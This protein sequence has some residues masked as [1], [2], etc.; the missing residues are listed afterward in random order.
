MRQAINPQQLLRHLGTGIAVSI[1]LIFV[2]L[3][4]VSG[5]T[6]GLRDINSIEYAVIARNLARTGHFATDILKPLSL[7]RFPTV[8]D[9]PDLIY[10]PLH[11]LWESLWMRM[12]GDP[13]K[14]V[15]LASGAWL[16]LGGL[17]MLWLGTVWFDAR[18][19]CAAALLYV[20]NVNMLDLAADGTEAPMLAFFLLGLIAAVASF[21]ADATK[22]AWKAAVIG[23]LAGLLYLTKYVWGLAIIPAAAA[24]FV[25]A[26]PRDRAKL[27]GLAVGSFVAVLLPWLVRSALLT[28]DPLFSFR[29]LES[30]MQTRTYPGNTLYRRVTEDYPSWLLFAATSPREILE[31][32]RRGLELIYAH[33]VVAAGPFVGAFFVAAIPAALARRGFEVARVVLYA[34]YVLVAMALLVLFPAARLTAPLAAPATLIGVAFFAK[35]L[36][37]ST[38]SLSATAQRRWMAAGLIALAV[39]HVVPVATRMTAGRPERALNTEALRTRAR[40]VA[41]LVDGPVVADVPWPLS[42]FG[43]VT[44]IWLPVDVAELRKVEDVIGPVKWLL[45]TPLTQR[46]RRSERAEHWY[47]VWARALRADVVQ[48][49][50]AVYK[51]LPGDWI[52]FQRTLVPSAAGRR[53]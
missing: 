48:D 8:G 6:G 14:A 5:Q 4:F 11:P 35:L 18:V 19:G 49:G 31:K 24:V 43:D 37:G 50:Y 16:F 39:V 20:L 3:L 51:R 1:G 29:W 15:P 44:T 25:L 34:A 42:W 32:A 53:E 52:L 22:K 17:L 2:Y 27:T 41:S 10:A 23:V 21:T 36:S 33:P 26:A 45:L 38:S 12:I 30:V 40:Q 47:R 7:A 46:I 13:E 9:H 28:G